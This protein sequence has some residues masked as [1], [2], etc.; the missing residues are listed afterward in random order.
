MKQANRIVWLITALAICLP[1]VTGLVPRPQ[2]AV[3]AVEFHAI[4]A[5]S[6]FQAVL[7]VGAAVLFLMG[8]K[9]FKTLLRWAYFA[10]C[11]GLILFAVTYLLVPFFHAFNLFD[12]AWF[13]NGGVAIVY[14]FGMVWVVFGLSA[15][16]HGLGSRGVWAKQSFLLCVPLAL[17][18]A[19]GFLARQHVLFVEFA[20]PFA[21]AAFT[22]V[23]ASLAL[24]IKRTAGAAYTYAMAWLFL[25]LVICTISGIWA[26]V[27]IF[28]GNAQ[29]P[30]QIIPSLTSGIVFV[31]AGYAFNKVKEY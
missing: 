14:A 2:S 7:H 23:A 27:Q 19:A 18:V 29:E 16:A 31:K 5:V 3:G 8:L 21:S 20:S 1:L 10:I 26:T 24:Y 13:K 25:A 28:F 15:F 4:L 11:T 9:G 6:I 30:L 22:I 17:T 12:S